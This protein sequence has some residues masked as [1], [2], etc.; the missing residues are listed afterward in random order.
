LGES[1]WNAYACPDCGQYIIMDNRAYK[2]GSWSRTDAFFSAKVQ[3]DKIHFNGCRKV[4]DHAVSQLIYM[5]LNTHRTEFQWYHDKKSHTYIV[6]IDNSKAWTFTDDG[7]LIRST[8]GPWRQ[9]I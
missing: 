4:T 7:K 1:R 8:H 9:F 6:A 3:F 2:G 5:R